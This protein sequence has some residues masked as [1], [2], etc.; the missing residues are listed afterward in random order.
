[1]RDIR[2][3]AHVRGFEDKVRETR[4]RWFGHVQRRDREYIG[5][6]ML[7]FELPGK[8]SRGRP[9]RRYMDVVREDMKAVGAREEDVED[10]GRW[11]QLTRCGDP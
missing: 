9:K 11:R 3:T 4:L 6:R 10:R 7:D 8:R 2:G 5:R 1:M